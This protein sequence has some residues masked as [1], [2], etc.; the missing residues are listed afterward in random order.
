MQRLRQGEKM[1]QYANS[2]MSKAIDEYIHYIRD[3]QILKDRL[4]DGMTYSELSVKY[5]LSERHIKTIVK[6]AV[7]CYN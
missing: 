3:R 7:F 2:E 6:K 5:N 1:K 4:I